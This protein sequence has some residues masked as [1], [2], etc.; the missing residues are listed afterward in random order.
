[1]VMETLNN[2]NISSEVFDYEMVLNSMNTLEGYFKDFAVALNDVNKLIVDS[3]NV[4][5]D[6]AL[7][8][9]LG[10][11]FLNVIYGTV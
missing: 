11:K 3:I 4:N 8:G 6:S 1:M 5:A 7:Y 10:K 2:T 9:D